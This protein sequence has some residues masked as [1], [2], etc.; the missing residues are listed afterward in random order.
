MAVKTILGVFALTALGT[1][2]SAKSTHNP[3]PARFGA[4]DLVRLQRIS[5]PVEAPDEIGR[6]SCRERV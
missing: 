5:D 2:A 3:A 4:Q 6:A 1:I